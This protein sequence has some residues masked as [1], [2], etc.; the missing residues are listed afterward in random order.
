MISVSL[1][2]ER[3]G[4][5][6]TAFNCHGFLMNSSC[7]KPADLSVKLAPWC[8]WSLYYSSSQTPRFSRLLFYVCEVVSPF[9][10]VHDRSLPCLCSLRLLLCPIFYTFSVF[11]L[12]L[13]LRPNMSMAVSMITFF[14]RLWESFIDASSPGSLFIKTKR[15]RRS[16]NT[17]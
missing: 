1:K 10:E 11:W 6:L 9:H 7:Q 2:C 15:W 17:W 5:D 4:L 13:W 8:Y 3:F 16:I 12:F 14:S